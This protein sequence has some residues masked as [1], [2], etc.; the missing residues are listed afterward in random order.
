[1]GKFRERG[2]VRYERGLPLAVNVGSL[3]TYLSG[4][5]RNE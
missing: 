4:E 1:M 5:L 2:L 3:T